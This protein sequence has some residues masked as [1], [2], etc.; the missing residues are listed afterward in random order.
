MQP[1]PKTDKFLHAKLPI[2]QDEKILAIYKHHWFAYAATLLVSGVIIVVIMGILLYVTA[3]QATTSS[4]ANNKAIILAVGAV[5]SLLVAVFSLIPLW[6]KSQEQMVLTEE[7]ILQILQPTMF[8]N[9]IS[10][11]NLQHVADVSVRQDFWGTMFNFGKITIETPGEQDNYEFTEVSKP[12]D[13]AREIIDAHENFQAALQS[14]RI[15]T[16][17][18]QPLA[19]PEVP[20]IDAAQYQQFLAFQKTMAAQQVAQTPPTPA[21]SQTAN[22]PVEQAPPQQNPTPQQ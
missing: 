13:V 3:T 1:T 17:L 5:F 11:L 12:Q 18:G 8:A 21:P 9:K 15:A 4:I 19:T 22:N 6:L 16:T 20:P 14:G 2:S 7:A 10:Q